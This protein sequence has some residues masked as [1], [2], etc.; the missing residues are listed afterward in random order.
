MRSMKRTVKA[1]IGRFAPNMLE[2]AIRLRHAFQKTKLQRNIRQTPPLPEEELRRWELAP[3]RQLDIEITNI[4]NADCLFCGYQYQQRPHGFIDETLFQRAVLQFKKM[5][6]QTL[7]VS[8]LVGEN[9]VHKKCLSMLQF[10]GRQN[11]DSIL[12]ITNGIL[13]YKTD[14]NALLKSGVTAISISMSGFDK[15]EYQRIYRN[16]SYDKLMRGVTQLLEAN[17][18]LGHPVTIALQIRSEAPPYTNLHRPDY[19]TMIAPYVQS[20]K[21]QVNFGAIYDSWGEMIKP[22]DLPGPF[23]KLDTIIKDMKIPCYG[24][25]RLKLQ[26]DGKVEVCGCRFTNKGHPDDLLIG[27]LNE[28]TLEEIWGGERIKAFRRRFLNDSLPYICKS[29]CHYF[30][31]DRCYDFTSTSKGA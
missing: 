24:A 16:R 7:V 25:F 8:P 4:C 18:A 28:N 10:A 27:H 9:L 5:G 1:W 29:C 30:P 31:A 2:R 6:G 19:Q 26:Y 14:L 13:L 3:V 15:E 11:F 20:D 23:M 17:K 12:F 21:V 22:E